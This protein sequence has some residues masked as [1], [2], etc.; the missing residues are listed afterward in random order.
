[1]RA[2]AHTF[3]VCLVITLIM[4]FAIPVVAAGEI[5]VEW[6]SDATEESARRR[7]GEAE[8]GEAK[9]AA[10]EGK[11]RLKHGDLINALINAGHSPIW[12]TVR[13]GGEGG[14]G[15]VTELACAACGAKQKS[16]PLNRFGGLSPDSPCPAAGQT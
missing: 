16:A 9:R 8:K 11:W 6:P 5:T 3:S 7:E 4:S 15:W 13:T 12:R 10:A 1:M 14:G 2:C